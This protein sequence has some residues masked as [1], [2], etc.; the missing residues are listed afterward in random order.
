MTTPYLPPSLRDFRPL[1]FVFSTWTPHMASGFD[2][3]QAIRPKLLVELGTQRGQSFFTFC[4]G[5]KAAGVDGVAYG[6]DTFE[7]DAHTG[8][9]DAGVFQSVNTHLGQNYAGFAYLLRMYFAEA[10]GHFSDDTIELLHIDGLHTYDAVRED[11]EGWYPKVAPGGIVLFHDIRARIQD[12][13]AWKYWD[14]LEA[15]A[16]EAGWECF[17]FD[18]GFGLGVLRKPGGER[19]DDA[20]L[21]E[22]L[23]QPTDGGAGLRAFYAHAARHLE[24]DRQDRIR[25]EKKRAAKAD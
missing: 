1:H 19:Q 18:H 8:P 17:A 24:L 5:M 20:P 16:G 15:R 13:G 2:L 23:F 10:L 7:G 9:D 22:M 11:F 12:F 14:E 25:R 3:V 6:V 21:L 4:Q